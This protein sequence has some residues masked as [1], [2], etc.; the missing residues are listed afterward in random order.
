MARNVFS[1]SL[2]ISALSDEDT[3][4]TVSKILENTCAASSVQSAVSPPT[5]FGTLRTCHCLFAGS[6]R[7]GANATQKST[8]HLRPAA[9]SM[10]TKSSCVVPG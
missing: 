10:G 9:S 5:T 3:G 4:T 7:S 6:M 2:T 8:P 1:S